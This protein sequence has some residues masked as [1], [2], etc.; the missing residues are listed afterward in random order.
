VGADD[1]GNFV[2]VWNSYQFDGAFGSIVAKRYASGGSALGSEFMVN[3]FTVGTQANPAVAV[4]AD[5]DFVSAWES[6][7]G[8][9]TGIFARRF[10]S[11]GVPA[12]TEFRAN[13]ETAQAQQHA[14]VASADAGEFIIAWESLSQ[15]DDAFGI[16]AQRYDS[17][18]APAGSEFL[19]NSYTQGN[20]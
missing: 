3:T 7:Y 1:L 20:Q 9:S 4:D 11:M 2:V 18:G 8:F 15:D 19:V 14:T 5:G 17:S 10:D 16:F 12:G 13:A 6:D